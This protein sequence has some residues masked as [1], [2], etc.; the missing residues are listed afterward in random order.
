MQSHQKR[1]EQRFGFMKRKNNKILELGCYK[2]EMSKWFSDNLLDNKNSELHCVD[3]WEGSIEYKK[4]F[5]N[6]KKK[7]KNDI[8]K[9]F[10]KHIKDSKHPTKVKI[11]KCTTTNYFLKFFSKHKNPFFDLIYVDASHD[12]RNVILDAIL[13]FKS[14]KIGGHIVFDDYEWNKM[15]KNYE[16]PKVAIIAFNHIFRDNIKI[17]HK[18]YKMIIKKVKEYKSL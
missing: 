18:G 16:R 5:N 15:P 11:H 17:I 6:V 8:E 7:F 13:S 3:T 1:W 14:L 12:A 2:G 10:K 9:T 4:N